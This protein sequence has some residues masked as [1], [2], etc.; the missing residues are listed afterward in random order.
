RRQENRSDFDR[1]QEVRAMNRPSQWTGMAFLSPSLV[2]FLSFTL[3]P[4]IGAVALSL[5]EWDLF[6]APRFVGLENYKQLLGGGMVDGVREWGDPQFWKF[7]GNT[8]YF[9]AAIPV[10]MGAS[11]W[12]AILLNKRI[13]FR[14]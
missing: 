8:L 12:L 2:G 14:S 5:C 3:L 10:S 13:P 7:L 9:M 6:H 1:R 4:V 11:L